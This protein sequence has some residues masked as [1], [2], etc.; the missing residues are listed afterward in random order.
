MIS[1]K[2]IVRIAGGSAFWGDTS[3]SIAALLPEARLDY[4]M[5]EYLAEITMAL[6]ARARSKSDEAGFVPD[7]VT[8]I[9]PHLPILKARG[10]KLV[11]NAGGMNPA[12]CARALRAA[13]EAQGVEL[14]IAIVEGDD[15]LAR[16]EEFRDQGIGDWRSGAAL[17]T[18]DALLS[19]NAYLGATPIA[20]A[21]D[22]GAEV[23]ITGR[24]VDSAL[25]LGPLM[26]EFGWASDD[27]DLMAA[28]SV[29]GHLIECGPQVT[30]GNFTDWQRVPGWENIGYPIAECAA[31]GSFIVTKPE[32]SG[33]L[34]SVQTVGEQLLY[35]IDDPASYLLPDVTV[36]LRSVE[37]LQAGPDRVLVRGARGRAATGLYKATVTASAGYRST[38]VFMIGG[39]DAAAKAGRVAEAILA[40][41]HNTFRS[42]NLGDFTETS[43]EIL[44]AEATYG[45]HA[46]ATTTREVMVKIAVKHPSKPALELFAR[47]VAP[48]SI[49][50]APG[51]TGFYAGRPN[52][53]PVIASSSALIPM[54]E[55][56]VRVTL[57]GR[58]LMECV[59]TPSAEG[60]PRPDLAP[61]AAAKPDEPLASVSLVEV[62][63]ARSGDKG[64][65]SLIAILA[66]KPEYLPFIARSITA[67]A[68][69]VW[70]GHV[71]K[72][73]VQ[74][75]DVPATNAFIFQLRNALGGGGLAS[76]R[77]DPQGKAFGQRLLDMPVDIPARWIGQHGLSG[78]DSM[79]A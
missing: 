57:D 27:F 60:A 75:F 33:G 20:A 32:G 31:D 52:V 78:P 40:R 38:A 30:G 67:E 54:A 25:V 35:E 12:A 2:K 3:S 49:A 10:I 5:L 58:A 17:P 7:F 65:D 34:V 9:A 48:A 13:A 1:A 22:E 45:P 39:L 74:R 66:R 23:V 41:C 28:G 73:E 51:I 29:C 37:L 21:L 46:R 4:L 18:A 62:A 15:L 55:V 56:P 64:D 42:T 43:V 24:N 50:M 71:L 11:T 6:L 63:H 77:I 70:F 53:S 14:R 8:A 44:G 36:D 19:M 68:V 72:G 26:H 69:A 76:L 47:D 61:I 59:V 79:A 16:A